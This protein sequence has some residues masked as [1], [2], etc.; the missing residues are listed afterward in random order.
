MFNWFKSSKEITV[1]YGKG[2]DS[3]DFIKSGKI[4]QTIQGE[5]ASKIKTLFLMQEKSQEFNTR[6]LEWTRMKE[7]FLALNC[8]GV[9]KYLLNNYE[10][11]PRAYN[12]LPILSEADSSYNYPYGLGLLSVE[13]NKMYLNEDWQPPVGVVVHTVAVLFS[14]NVKYV[15][16]K[17]KGGMIEI[18]TIDDVIKQYEK[19]FKQKI[20][21]IKISKDNFL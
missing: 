10:Q 9:T 18:L 3:V 2:V 1:D 7:N 5:L 6:S 15:L 14:K 12:N 8:Y 19:I 21:L 13:K 11:E 17:S 20:K 4:I 16:S